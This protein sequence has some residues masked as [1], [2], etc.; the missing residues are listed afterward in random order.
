M[1]TR[2]VEGAENPAST[3]RSQAT[4]VP[5]SA[6]GTPTV[7]PVTRRRPDADRIVAPLATR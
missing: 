6:P 1:E 2:F 5:D 7:T 4:F 3:T